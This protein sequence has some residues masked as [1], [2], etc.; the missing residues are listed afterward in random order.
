MCPCS[1]GSVSTPREKVAVLGEGS[2][3]PD[4]LGVFSQEALVWREESWAQMP[5]AQRVRLGK[6]EGTV[7]EGPQKGH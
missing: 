3:L 1:S 2:H 5:A 4:L 6:G 7:S